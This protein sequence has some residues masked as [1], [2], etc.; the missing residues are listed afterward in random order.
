MA[1]NSAHWHSISY[2]VWTAIRKHVYQS[3]KIPGLPCNQSKL[4]TSPRQVCW[5]DLFACH[6][7]SNGRSHFAV[8]PGQCWGRPIMI[9]RVFIR[10]FFPRNLYFDNILLFPFYWVISKV[11]IVSNSAENIKKTNLF[12]DSWAFPKFEFYR[13]S[14]IDKIFLG[15][16]NFDCITRRSW[17]RSL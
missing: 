15:W 11:G 9:D 16:R 14:I 2:V 5:E 3:K 7:L 1:Q 6:G 4:Q 8:E 10:E 17:Y 12:W 13:R